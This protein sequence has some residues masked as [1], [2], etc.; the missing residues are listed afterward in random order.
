MATYATLRNGSSGEDVKKLQQ[1]LTNAGYNTGG[2]DGIFGA[3]T[4]SALKQY[5]TANGLTADGV[6]GDQTFGKL[7][8]MSQGTGG[9][10]Q[11]KTAMDI[12]V[13][14]PRDYSGYS[15]RPD[16][17]AAQKYMYNAETDGAY[18]AAMAALNEAQKNRPAYQATYDGDIQ[19]AYQRIMSRKPFSYDP[20]TDPAYQQYRSQYISQGQQAMRDTVA[21]GA[22]LTGGYGNTYAQSAGQQ[23]YD[24]YLQRL[25]DVLPQLRSEARQAYNDEGN[26][27][28]RQFSMM[29]DLGETEYNRSRDA[30]SDWRADRDYA[31][32][33]ADTLYSRGAEN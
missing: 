13:N 30:L 11:G 19:A 3:N 33:R 27:L 2:V 28:Y 7:Y 4:E 29:R 15:Y 8:G 1:A 23:A 32:Q 22:A 9:A 16:S 21:Q 12:A 24:A 5:Q 26:D 10:E 18:Q 25:N 20:E 17:G 14:Q 31:Q 6:A